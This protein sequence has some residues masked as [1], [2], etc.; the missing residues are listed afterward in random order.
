M[1]RRCS[2]G[3]F[4]P[5]ELARDAHDTVNVALVAA[6]LWRLRAPPADAIM[7]RRVPPSAVLTDETRLKRHFEPNFSLGARRD[8]LLRPFRRCSR[9]ITCNPE[10]SNRLLLAASI[11]Q[12]SATRCK[13]E[14]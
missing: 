13:M 8:F 12:P 3:A 1:A 11:S 2:A 6:H 7:A 10:N 14:P 9:S 4:Q 5:T